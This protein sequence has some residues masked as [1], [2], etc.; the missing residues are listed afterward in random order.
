MSIH[1]TPLSSQEPHCSTT[2]K[3]LSYHYYDISCP[4]IMTSTLRLFMALQFLALACG[5]LSPSSVPARPLRVLHSIP[6]AEE[7]GTIAPTGYITR[8]WTLMVIAMCGSL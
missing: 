4:S 3:T 6:K 5:F 8:K 7:A 2:T 1:P